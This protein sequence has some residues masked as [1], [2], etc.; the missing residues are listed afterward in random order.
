M[1]S[2]FEKIGPNR[3]VRWCNPRA[4][5]DRGGERDA[6]EEVESFDSFFLIVVF[7]FK[8]ELVEMM[9]EKRTGEYKDYI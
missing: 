6:G 5:I 3:V 8:F 1:G 9:E 4:D 7:F 2:I